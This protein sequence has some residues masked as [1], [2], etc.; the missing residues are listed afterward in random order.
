M[1][2]K[3]QSSSPEDVAIGLQ[4]QA[5]LRSSSASSSSRSTL[6]S[7]ASTELSRTDT[8]ASSVSS[9]P[10]SLSKC[11]SG[12][13]PP[14]GQ[15]DTPAPATSITGTPT[16]GGL[17]GIRDLTHDEHNEC[18]GSHPGTLWAGFYVN[19][20]TKQFEHTSENLPSSPLNRK[21]SNSGSSE[22]I[23]EGRY[24]FSRKASNEHIMNNLIEKM[25]YTADLIGDL[26][27]PDLE[28][29]GYDGIKFHD[30]IRVKHMRAFPEF[31]KEPTQ[32]IS[33]GGW[34]IVRGFLPWT[35]SGKFTTFEKYLHAQS[36]TSYDLQARKFNITY[37]HVGKFIDAK[38]T[39][40]SRVD[41]AELYHVYDYGE[42]VMDPSDG[43]HMSTWAK[44]PR[45]TPRVQLEFQRRLQNQARPDPGQQRRRH[46]AQP[47]NP[48]LQQ[49]SQAL[50]QQE[51]QPVVPMY[52]R[53]H[54]IQQ[55]QSP[56]SQRNPRSIPPSQTRRL[57]N[58]R[59]DRELARELEKREKILDLE[60]QQKPP[61]LS[62]QRQYRPR[63][64]RA[65]EAIRN[66]GRRQPMNPNGYTKVGGVTCGILRKS[67]GKDIPK[68]DTAILIGKAKTEPARVPSRKIA[69][70]RA[71]AE[72]EPTFIPARMTRNPVRLCARSAIRLPK[73]EED[74]DDNAIE[75]SGEESGQGSKASGSESGGP[76]PVPVVK[77]VKWKGK[78]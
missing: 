11:Q 59:R 10:Q 16:V 37:D 65:E 38:D 48:R 57:L 13:T 27:G 69:F 58:A 40:P 18:W 29:P 8:F 25:G 17:S 4:G 55:N 51:C 43:D 60:D 66:T 6:L 44:T 50:A 32:E 5:L 35:E 28:I 30:V 56:E 42:S 15:V 68:V 33:S 62:Q 3:L 2:K 54:V 75:S 36:W 20:D 31:F 71:P 61:Q 52:V 39:N 26:V 72:V 76:K 53:S 41:L 64:E 21:K 78:D 1:I 74:V 7:F 47:L 70:Q 9:Y 73:P 34:R 23:G 77:H 67:K 19:P 22:M 46:T 45:N 63:R 24:R 14:S 12:S 49:Q